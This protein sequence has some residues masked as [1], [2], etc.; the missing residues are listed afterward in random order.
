MKEGDMQIGGGCFR[1]VT[2]PGPIKI[3]DQHA[4]DCFLCTEPIING[5]PCGNIKHDGMS[6]VVCMACKKKMEDEKK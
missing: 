5:E 4:F 3:R 1:K 6:K 2:P